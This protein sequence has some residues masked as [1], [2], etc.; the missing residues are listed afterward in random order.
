VHEWHAK[1]GLS[2]TERLRHSSTP[3]RQSMRDRRHMPQDGAATNMCQ[4]LSNQTPARGEPVKAVSRIHTRE[5]PPESNTAVSVRR[6]WSVRLKDRP[7]DEQVSAAGRSSV[8]RRKRAA[9]RVVVG[10]P[11]SVVPVACTSAAQQGSEHSGMHQRQPNHP[12]PSR[13]KKAQDLPLPRLWN[14]L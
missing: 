6:D 3:R 8:W 7:S 13:H 4:P 9:L 2:H 10:G 12:P 11:K 14:H 5:A 1:H